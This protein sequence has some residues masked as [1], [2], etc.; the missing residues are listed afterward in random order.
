[1]SVR[2]KKVQNKMSGSE[3]FGKWYGRA[4]MLDT[5]STKELADEISHAS[6]VTYADVMAVLAEMQHAIKNHLQNSHKVALEGLGVLG[7]AMQTKL[8]KTRK[9]FT[10]NNI[11]GYRVV[12]YPEVKFV[13]SGE[14]SESG[15]RKGAFVKTLLEG[16]TAKELG[17]DDVK[18]QTTG[19]QTGGDAGSGK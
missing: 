17:G 18:E 4:I 12:F 13:P 9:E 19:G 15:K 2:F 5:I 1:M 11:K 7:V 10:A 16:I 14:I 3:N 6:T 8:A